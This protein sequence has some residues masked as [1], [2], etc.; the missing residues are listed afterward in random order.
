[1]LKPTALDLSV[2]A[3]LGTSPRAT[4]NE[5][6]NNIG[7]SLPS[8]RSSINKLIS[9]GIMRIVSVTDPAA[10]GHTVMGVTLIQVHPSKLDTLTNQLKSNP[11]I[12]AMAL[13]IGAFNCM[14]WT[15][16]EDSKQMRQFLDSDLG[17]M[18][19]VVN[20]ESLIVL[21]TKKASTNL[22]SDN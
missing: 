4:L 13:T 5:L 14:I 7:V 19:G 17:G 18:P 2:M 20:Y 3:E 10:F 8:V 6:A 21:G 15:S 16:F 22:M 9:Q 12:I 1:M 11:G